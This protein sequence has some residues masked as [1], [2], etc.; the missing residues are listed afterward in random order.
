MCVAAIAKTVGP[1]RNRPRGDVDAGS[2]DLSLV[3]GYSLARPTVKRVDYNRTSGEELDRS[4][5]GRL[6][7]SNLA[8]A[9]SR[10]ASSKT[11]QRLIE[12]PSTV[13]M[14]IARHSA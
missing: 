2:F 6:S 5:G 4:G 14:S 7:S 1:Q 12:S 3:A 13:K 11:S 10:S 9:A 8:S